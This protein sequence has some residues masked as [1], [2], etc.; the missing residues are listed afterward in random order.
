MDT[1]ERVK[2]G[3]S[4]DREFLQTASQDEEARRQAATTG[5]APKPPN[6]A[7][8]PVPATPATPAEQPG[9]PGQTERPNKKVKKGKKKGNKKEEDAGQRGPTT[10]SQ[11]QEKVEE[12]ERAFVGKQ[13]TS[14][15][16]T[17]ISSIPT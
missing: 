11:A 17:V 16:S 2:E 14:S 3:A 10:T 8:S 6:E 13:R 12:E 4:E 5:T 15:T 9:Q 7:P 1:D